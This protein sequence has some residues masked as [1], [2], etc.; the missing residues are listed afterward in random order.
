ML[1]LDPFKAHYLLSIFASLKLQL[2]KIF[3]SSLSLLILMLLATNTH[4]QQN[5]V[6]DGETYS[7]KTDIEGSITLLWNTIDGEYRYFLKK[8]DQIIEL[9]NTK[10]NG[11]YQEE[12]KD[13][14]RAQT[15]KFNIS[16]EKVNL[17]LPSL[18]NFL[19]EYNSLVDPSFIEEK[20]SINLQFRLGAFTGV[21]NSIYTENPNNDLQILAGIDFE[22]L[23]P[24][25]L[26]RHAAVVQFKQTFESN[27]YKYSA[28]QFSLNYRFKFVKTSKLDIYIHTK[29][30]ALTFSSKEIAIP[31]SDDPL[32]YENHKT[33]GSSFTAPI[34]F[35][36][37]ADY[38]VGNGYVTFGYNDI[39]SLNLDRENKS[40]P[41]DFS[42]GYKFNL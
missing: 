20:E 39:V 4:A 11:K 31:I 15:S 23:D 34:S 38:K 27:D 33:S 16:P 5:Y 9:K 19:A 42:L 21:S 1:I 8:E 24:I 37:G 14:L 6:V 2:M 26:K 28:S 12:Y 10:Q 35:G 30:A 40:F 36:L 32:N 18:H 17:T 22:I 29:L 41:M 25:K 13:I 7:L 3:F